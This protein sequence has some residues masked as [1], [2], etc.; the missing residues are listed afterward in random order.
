MKTDDA[1]DELHELPGTTQPQ[2][3]DDEPE[4]LPDDPDLQGLPGEDKL[5]G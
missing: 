1:F 2:P 4:V 3:I 5:P